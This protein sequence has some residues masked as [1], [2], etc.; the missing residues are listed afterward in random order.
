MK[1]GTVVTQTLLGLLVL[2]SLSG[3]QMAAADNAAAPTYSA[4]DFIIF[5]DNPF[6][7][8]IPGI[9]TDDDFGYTYGI[10]LAYSQIR[11][12]GLLTPNERWTVAFRT[13]LYTQD[14]TPP[15]QDLFPDVPQKFMEVSMLKLTW[16][17]LFDVIDGRKIYYV[18]GVGIGL[19]NNER[20]SGFLAAGQQRA[21]H[22]FK[23]NHLTPDTTPIYANEYG[24][25]YQYFP[26]AKL[27]LGHAVA[28][29]DQMRAY[30]C[31]ADRFK[32]E[33]GA[34]FID[35]SRGSYAYALA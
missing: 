22:T 18:A 16:D 21:W 11:T 9:S 3:A 6:L 2:T 34:E 28:F 12:K 15:G 19:M 33:G 35:Q 4:V 24:D 10:A 27:A 30:H 13:D 29:S 26:T 8:L 14:L 25:T 7:N 20:D 17:N 5:N 31:E 32:I 23:H 1:K